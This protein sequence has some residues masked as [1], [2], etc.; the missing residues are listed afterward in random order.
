MDTTLTFATWTA[1]LTARGF[2]VLPSSHAVPVELWLRT[3]I[4]GGGNE[5]LHLRARGTS[6]TLRRYSATAL[7][8]LI[9]RSECDC[10]EHRTAGAATRVA[11]MPGA[12]ALAEAV[13]D[14]TA[15]EGWVGHT[16]GLL[17]VPTAAAL[18]ERLLD[19]LTEKTSTRVA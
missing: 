14:G 18:F 2:T 8:G 10:E 3:P 11:L 7:A 16:A 12:V 1:A 9:L 17:G 6:V 19:E 5:V 15:E 4:R 13:Y